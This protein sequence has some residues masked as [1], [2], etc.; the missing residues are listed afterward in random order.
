MGK[1]IMVTGGARSG[2]STFAEKIA[3]QFENV[4]YVATSIPFDDGMEHRI[5]KHR[6]QRPSSWETIEQYKDFENVFNMDSYKK[7]ELLL[8]DCLTVM[9]TN[10]MFYSEM[11]FDECTPEDVDK[12]EKD[13]KKEVEDLLRLSDNKQ[14][15]IVTNELGMGLVPAYK[16]GNYFRDIAGRMNQYVASMADEVYLV[17]SGIEMKLK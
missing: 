13:I 7:S 16:M 8:V 9:I 4:A 5:K 1:I 15:I 10:L 2:K 11:D 17:V 3:R 6:E 12:L 14:M